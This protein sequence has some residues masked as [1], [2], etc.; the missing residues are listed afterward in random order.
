MLIYIHIYIYV[1]IFGV[2]DICKYI[3]IYNMY[4]IYINDIYNIIC[5]I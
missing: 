1:Y 3:N 2:Y 5:Y 4:L